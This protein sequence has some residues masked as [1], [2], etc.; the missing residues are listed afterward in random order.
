MMCLFNSLPTLSVI[1]MCIGQVTQL[2]NVPVVAAR[3]SLGLDLLKNVKDSGVSKLAINSNSV[4]S[5]GKRPGRFCQTLGPCRAAG[6][7]SAC[8]VNIPKILSVVYHSLVLITAG[9]LNM[10]NGQ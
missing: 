3:K 9:K 5:A 6:K 4:S 10:A 7:I 1:Y 2:S 8:S